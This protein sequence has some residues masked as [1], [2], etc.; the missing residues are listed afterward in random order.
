MEGRYAVVKVAGAE[1]E[2]FWIIWEEPPGTLPK[3]SFVKTSQNLSEHGVRTELAKRGI[4]K[5]DIDSLIE[6]ARRSPK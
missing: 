6:Q 5:T 2:T 4:A 1:P 3:G